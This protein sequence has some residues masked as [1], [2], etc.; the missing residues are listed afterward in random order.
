[1]YTK[2]QFSERAGALHCLDYKDNNGAIVK[3]KQRDYYSEKAHS[4]TIKTNPKALFDAG[5]GG[6]TLYTWMN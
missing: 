2:Q 3:R 1:M 5:K 6:H 4:H